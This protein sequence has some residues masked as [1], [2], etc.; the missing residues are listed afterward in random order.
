M[1]EDPFAPIDQGVAATRTKDDWH[2]LLPVPSGA[3]RA[4]ASHHR[5]GKPTAT[6][7][8]RD[9]SGQVLGFVRRF[10]TPDGKV[11]QPQT[12]GSRAPGAKPEW[13]W[14]GWTGKRPLYGL[15][16]LAER[17]TAPVVVTEGEKAADAAALLLPDMVAVTSPNGSKSAAK[18]DWS[19]LRGRR[20]TIWPD[21]D[22]AG[23]DYANAVAKLAAAAEA[24]S[25]AIISPPAGC[26]I[27][28]DAA[29][30]KDGGWDSA[31]ATQLVT[32]ARLPPNG[33]VPNEA[34]ESSR[35]KRPPQ[36][37]VVIDL[38]D[39]CEFWHDANRMAYATFP[40]NS[41]F[42]NWAVRSREFRMW[43]SGQYYEATGRALG[44]QALEDAIRI[45]EARAVY[46]GKQY[47]PFIRVG[48]TAGKIYVDLCDSR[49]QAVEVTRNDWRL[50]GS[51]PVK[52]MRP[53]SLRSMPEPE[54]GGMIEELLRFINVSEDQYMLIVGWLVSTLRPK[55]PFPILV[56]N[57][58]Q[59]SGKS[60]AC[61]MLRAL[62]DPSAAAIR[63][64]PKDDHNLIVSASNSHVLGFDNLSEVP[65]W[66]ADAFC[67]LSTG[68]GY[69]TRMLHT[70]RDEMIFEGQ[71]PIM[72]NGIPLLTNRADLADRAITI[73]LRAI[74][75]TD[76]KPE[77]EIWVDF[78]AA[79]PR[80]FGALLSAI[81]ASLR[82]IGTTKLQQSGRMADFEKLVT[83]AESGLGWEPGRFQQAVRDNRHEISESAFE[84]DSVAVA[85]AKLVRT[86]F[87]D[88]MVK[89]ATE[90]L[91]LLN[92]TDLVSENI[93]KQRYWP[94]TPQG[95]GNRIDRIA[96]LLKAQGFTIERKHSGVRNIIIVPPGDAA[97]HE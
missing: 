15:D 4:P 42:E 78:E 13:R 62:V 90:L 29:D 79:R 72:L 30:A 3:P 97:P 80:M 9:A 19:P 96:P 91:A 67:R 22:A 12:F 88:G 44:S 43:L 83:A 17:P 26:S 69:A 56:A 5:H 82:N 7:C 51:A 58:E 59:G 53:A 63:S 68:G 86:D 41:H 93:R 16:R 8:Y 77:D 75:E 71:R 94:A 45:L 40:I 49:W 65:A 27:G 28:W 92:A 74:P 85:I 54:A 47:E 81:S 95:L 14:K 23:L 21:A 31:R 25:I 6:W 64:V 55:G 18:A 2:P 1:S 20:V 70:D 84:A 46:D 57:G 76:R 48:S 66:L 34:S 61:R 37:D 73:H 10:D 35:R 89:T 32:D 52:F 50:V 38:T 60:M 36:R 33:G 11:F 87:P 24:E 39:R